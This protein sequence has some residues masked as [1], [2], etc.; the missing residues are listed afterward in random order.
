MSALILICLVL[1]FVCELLAA[2]NIP[3]PPRINL[4]AL[5]L[6]FYFATLIPGL[7]R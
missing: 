6:A 4:M 2:F 7:I 3:T 5:G 1:A